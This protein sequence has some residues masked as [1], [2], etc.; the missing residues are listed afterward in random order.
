MA[1]YRR[2]IARLAFVPPMLIEAMQMRPDRS[3]SAT[4]KKRAR[5]DEISVLK[6]PS[7]STSEYLQNRCFVTSQYL[8]LYA[9]CNFH[10]KLNSVISGGSRRNLINWRGSL[11]PLRQRDEFDCS[12]AKIFKLTGSAGSPLAH[13]R[14]QKTTLR[15]RLH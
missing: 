8:Q 5:G 9:L 12:L 11:L 14:Y 10:Y 4:V 13:E 15:Y 7:S 1:E 2:A 3:W 6:F